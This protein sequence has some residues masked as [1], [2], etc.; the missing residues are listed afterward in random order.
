MN[1][2]NNNK[3]GYLKINNFA[4]IGHLIRLLKFFY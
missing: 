3:L 2:I 4:V 1:N